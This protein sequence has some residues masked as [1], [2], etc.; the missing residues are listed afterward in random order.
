MDTMKRQKCD[1]GT[2]VLP[3]LG[4][5][6]ETTQQTKHTL[7]LLQIKTLHGCQKIL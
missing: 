4:N 1:G 7:Y 3:A 2:K 6:K 5:A